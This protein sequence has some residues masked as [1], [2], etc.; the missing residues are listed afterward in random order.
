MVQVEESCI[1]TN[2]G[3]GEQKRSSVTPLT[4]ED[5]GDEARAFEGREPL[6]H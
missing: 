2:F 5:V 1:H 4:E 6:D 3:T